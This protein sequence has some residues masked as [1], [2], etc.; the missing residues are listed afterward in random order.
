MLFIKVIAYSLKKIESK[1]DIDNEIKSRKKFNKL[2]TNI[3]FYETIKTE[4]EESDLV[5]KDIEDINLEDDIK[6]PNE[7]LDKEAK[8]KQA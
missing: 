3:V 7:I 4:I 5:M 1:L 6:I 8:S 2:M